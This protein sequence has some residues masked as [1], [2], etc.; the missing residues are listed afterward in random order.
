MFANSLVWNFGCGFISV[1]VDFG[2]IAAYP[3]NDCVF[4]MI[5]GLIRV[6]M[7]TLSMFSIEE[8]FRIWLTHVSCWMTLGAIDIEVICVGKVNLIQ[9]TGRLMSLTEY[10]RPS[11]MRSV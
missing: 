5:W 1:L 6:Q 9:M 7:Y 2:D 11:I 10:F 3:M 8:S 4:L